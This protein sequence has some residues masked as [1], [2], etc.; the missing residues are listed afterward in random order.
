MK[1]LFNYS[2]EELAALDSRDL[3]L[4]LD[5]LKEL[6]REKGLLFADSEHNA[7]SKKALLPCILAELARILMDEKHVKINEAKLIAQGMPEYIKA[8]KDASSAQL[9]AN[10]LKAEYRGIIESLRALT[11]IS[12]VRN[13][14]L[15]LG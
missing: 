1:S 13:S 7:E 9:E 15:K 14:E 11:A 10:K 5:E 2:S 6:A 8:V 3:L 4:K 12:Y